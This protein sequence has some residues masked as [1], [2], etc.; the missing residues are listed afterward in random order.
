MSLNAVLAEFGDML[1]RTLGDAIEIRYDL[2]PLLPTCLVDPVHAEMAV[3]NVLA[4]ARDA[5]PRG[6]RA[7]VRTGIGAGGGDADRPGQRRDRPG[8]Y[9]ALT[10][11]D[12]GPG[13][14]PEVLARATEPFFT[15]KGPG[16]GTGLGLAMVHGFAHQSGG[17][18]EIDS[19]PGRGTTVRMLFPEANALPARPPPQA[20]SERG[21]PARRARDHPGGGRQ[22]RRAGP[23]GA[24][25]HLARLFG[26]LGAE[27]RGG[28]GTAGSH[29]RAG[30]P[31]VHRPRHARRHERA[32]AGRARAGDA[33]GLRDAATTGYNEELVA[34]GPPAEGMAPV[35][36]K[37]YAKT[38]LAAQVRAALDRPPPGEAGSPGRSGSGESTVAGR[39]KDG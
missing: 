27:R 21:G 7:T 14:P 18:L 9:V 38:D 37:P 8:R 17:R 2:D 33:P 35:L 29:R 28:A 19:A 22:Q 4:N 36:G 26:A 31:A 25:P 5:M 13:M 12:D 30:G 10:V 20:E 39:L 6:G 11:E 24:P 16:K 23:R 1:S 32:A 34:K 3:L 15:T